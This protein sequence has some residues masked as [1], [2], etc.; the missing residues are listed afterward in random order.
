MR[1]CDR[2]LG[3]VPAPM[4]ARE[5]QNPHLPSPR[6]LFL[7][8]SM[9]RTA[10]AASLATEYHP[11]TIRLSVATIRFSVGIAFWETHVRHQRPA[12]GDS[13]PLPSWEERLQVRPFIAA[14][15]KE[16]ETA[17]KE[18][19]MLTIF[20]YSA[21]ETDVEAVDLMLRGS[22]EN[23]PLISRKERSWISDHETTLKKRGNVS[24]VEPITARPMIFMANVSSSAAP[25]KL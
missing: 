25:P 9:F 17:L 15:W 3:G 7:P 21:P 12:P 23:P 19:Y 20:G 2:G 1:K 6:E 18:G 24:Y 10:S 16:L 14:E 11:F 4:T 13:T 8:F 5:K 22:G